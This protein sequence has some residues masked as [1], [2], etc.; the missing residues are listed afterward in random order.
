MDPF[1]MKEDIRKLRPQVDYVMVAIHWATSRSAEVGPE[2]R[3]F[4]HGLIDAGADVILGHHPPHPKGIEVY[5][6]KV[7]L[8]APSNVLRGHNGP[9]LDDGYLVRF[10]LGPKSVEKVEV[11]P[12]IGKGQPEGHTGPY[13]SKLFQPA[14]MQGTNARQ[15]LENLRSRSAALDTT[16][17]IDGEKGVIAI[18]QTNK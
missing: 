15:L 5:K 2:N 14:L 8:Y 4:A 7:I 17:S 10:T 6:G 9:A 13:D 1:L 11:L 18:S 16:M 12:I 3:A